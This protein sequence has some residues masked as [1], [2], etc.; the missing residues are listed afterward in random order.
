MTTCTA[1][2]AAWYLGHAACRRHRMDPTKPVR[3]C[4][5]TGCQ[6]FATR[7]EFCNYHAQKRYAIA[8]RA[9]VRL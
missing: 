3:F 7:R 2:R 8:R 9:E 4:S 1:C 5:A 6:R